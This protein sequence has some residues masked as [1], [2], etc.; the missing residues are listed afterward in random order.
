MSVKITCNKKKEDGLK[1]ALK[2]PLYIEEIVI[3]EI[4]R[5]RR[6]EKEWSGV[7]SGEWSDRGGRCH[8]P[9]TR[10]CPCYGQVY[11]TA[12]RQG[13]LNRS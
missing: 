7:W 6:K 1:L 10:Q 3:S 13:S 2:W 8:H 4:K 12:A 9:I 11:S 5:R